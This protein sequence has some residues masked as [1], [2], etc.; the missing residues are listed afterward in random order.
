[1]TLKEFKEKYNEDLTRVVQ[2]EK[3][4]RTDQFQNTIDQIMNP[5]L[6]KYHTISATPKKYVS[7]SQ[8]TR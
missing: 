4:T 5:F 7:F 1:M 6:R 8:I 2:T 3:K